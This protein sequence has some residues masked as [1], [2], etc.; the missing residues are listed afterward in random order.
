MANQRGK[1]WIVS[2]PAPDSWLAGYRGMTPILAQVLYNRGLTTPEDAAE[3]LAQRDIRHNPFRLADM[4]K[5]VARL[6]D[7]IKAGESIVVYGDF[8]ADGVTATALMVQGLTALGA[9]HVRAYIPNRVDEGYGLN[10][11]AID[12][13]YDEGHRLIITV[14]CGI[15]ALDEIAHARRR[16][17]DVIVTDHHSLGPE[18]PDAYAV[19][20]CKRPGYDE[21]M[22]A[23]VGVAFKVIDALRRAELSNG[24]SERAEMF[25]LT[26]LLD[27]VA[28]G[29]VADLMPLNHLE[30][31][32]LVRQGLDVLRSAR[33]PG[34]QALLDVSGISPESV[35]TSSIAFGIGPRINAAGRL[36]DAIDAYRLLSSSTANEAAPLA[37]LLQR[38]NTERQEK[39]RSA[40]D[41]IRS[42]IGDSFDGSLIFAGHR[43]LESGIVGLVA[44]RMV[45]EYFL[46]AIILEF[47]EE[48]SRASCRSIPEFDITA[49]LDQCADLLVRHGGHAL[50]AGFTVRNANIPMLR[51]RLSGLAHEALH[52]KTVEPTLE[53][54]AKIK[55][56]N[57]TDGL[58]EELAQLEPTGNGNRQPVFAMDR[59]HIVDARTVG[60]EDKH[61]KLRIARAGMGPLDAIGFGLGPILEDLDRFADIAFTLEFNTYRDRRS[62]QL[63]LEDVKPC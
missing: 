21:P 30:N 51:E 20:N 13:L 47:G 44:G 17:I 22:L 11:G 2:E 55:V 56:H 9:A 6:R 62:V 60:K 25:D 52:G 12:M 15:R 7:A 8:D 53:I 23:G 26:Q 37:D 16:G 34:I 29:T 36:S 45:E 31:R 42:E 49:A 39:T 1:R 3:F 32:S 46:P 38:L 5:A 40:Q 63:R 27:L 58:V 57:I 48:E 33:R 18:L 10:V 24:G 61:L 41:L 50:A 4:A 19:I 35:T 28:I 14:D 59:A 43:D 54:D